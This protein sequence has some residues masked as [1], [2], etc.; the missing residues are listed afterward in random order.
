VKVSLLSVNSDAVTV[1]Q[2]GTVSIDI[3]GNDEFPS[4]LAANQRVAQNVVKTDGGPIAGSI[5]FANNKILYTHDARAPLP[6]NVDSFRYEIVYQPSQGSPVSFT[7]FVYIYVLEA[8][9]G[10]FAACYGN[11]LITKLRESPTDIRFL[12]NQNPNISDIYPDNYTGGTGSGADSLTINFG[13]VT[14]PKT[15]KVKPLLSFYNNERIDF[16]PGDLTIGVLGENTGDKA[17]FRW[18]GEISTSW[19]DPRNWVEVKNGTETPVL[20]VPT[21]CVDVVIPSGVQRYPMLTAPATCANITMQNRAMIAGIHYLTYGSARVELTLNA[22]ERDRFIMWSAPLMSMYSGDYHF[23]IREDGWFPNRFKWGDVYMNY[24]QYRNPDGVPSSSA[25]YH[26]FTATFGSLGDALSLGKAFNL[27]VVSTTANKDSLFVFPQTFTSYRDVNN[28]STSPNFTRTNGNKFITHG[29]GA[30]FELPVLNDIDDSFSFS[31]SAYAQVVNPYMAYLKIDEFLTA[32]GSKVATNGFS[33]WDGETGSFT[34][35]VSIDYPDN[36]FRI[37][38]APSWESPSSNFVP[39]LQSFFV[40]KGGP[41]FFP[42]LG[43]LTMK[44]EWATTTP[45]SPYKLRAGEQETN[46]LRIKAVQDKQVSYAVLHYNESTSPAYNSKEDMPKLFYQLEEGVIPLEVYTFAPTKEVLAINS[47]SDFSQNVPLGLRTDK[48]GSVTLEFSGM[49]TFGHNVYLIDHAQNNKETDLQK[50]PAYTFT[51]T[52]K[53]AGDKLIEL[54]DRFSL[55]TTYTGIGLGNEAS[56]ATE[57]S[58]TAREGYLY[59]QTPSPVSSLQ[60]YSLT[61]ALV[62][63]STAALDY[64]RIPTDGQQAYIVKVKMNDQYIIRKAFVR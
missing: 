17:T 64:F 48:A 63:S 47:S 23:N 42:A 16:V 62:Y 22:A 56:A 43:T 54:N 38:T 21:T 6:N 40:A 59:V 34:Y 27:K 25:G 11:T 50:A 8:E 20:F 45:E 32:N 41:P 30:E 60:V 61:G 5:Q 37:S 15:Y 35:I 29:K 12:W 53:S 18:T 1:Q 3:F 7:A 36:R 28:V 52:K 44:E 58:V 19:D 4:D 31:G 46:I 10:G 14:T 49:A 51:V 24:F 57:V 26:A 33:I 2:Y 9:S 55:R 13:P 39:P